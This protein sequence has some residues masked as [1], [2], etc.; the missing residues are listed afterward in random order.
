M[1]WLPLVLLLGFAQPAQGQAIGMFGGQVLAGVSL[2]KL[3]KNDYQ[4]DFN[5]A[6]GGYSFPTSATFP[7]YSVGYNLY[8][9][10]A[11][12]WLSGDLPGAYELSEGY[13]FGFGGWAKFHAPPSSTV[14]VVASED[15]EGLFIFPGNVYSR[16][17]AGELVGRTT[18]IGDIPTEIGQSATWAQTPEPATLCLLGLGLLALTVRRKTSWAGSKSGVAFTFGETIEVGTEMS[19]KAPCTAN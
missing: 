6:W 17:I 12:G 15:I 10:S 16:F 5:W 4:L 18:L 19:S 8:A 9:P 13:S 7:G 2:T 11:R 14:D 3:G 1:R